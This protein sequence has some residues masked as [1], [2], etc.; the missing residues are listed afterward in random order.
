MDISSTIKWVRRCLNLT[1]GDFTIPRST[2]SILEAPNRGNPKLATLKSIADT[3]GM[4]PSELLA[5]HEARLGI[6]QE[7][8][9]TF[10]SILRKIKNAD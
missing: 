2:L 1:G 9:E 4:K 6:S 8:T 7:K 3:M 10:K 5:L